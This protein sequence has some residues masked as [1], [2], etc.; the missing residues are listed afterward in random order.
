MN[1]YELLNPHCQGAWRSLSTVLIFRLA[2]WSCRM[3]KQSEWKRTK[4]VQ[5]WKKINMM[6]ECREVLHIFRVMH[7]DWKEEEGG[8]QPRCDTIFSC[9]PVSHKGFSPCCC[10]GA[11]VHKSN[12]RCVFDLN[13]HRQVAGQKAVSTSQSRQSGLLCAGPS[14]SVRGIGA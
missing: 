7:S 10:L 11:R 8:N 4:K 14:L 1:F 3:W 12:R 9:S 6:K 13:N 2:L 5:R